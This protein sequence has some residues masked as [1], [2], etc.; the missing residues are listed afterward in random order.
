MTYDFKNNLNVWIRSSDYP[1]LSLILVD[2]GISQDSLSI[3]YMELL[4]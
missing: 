2:S 3:Q 1:I 4:K